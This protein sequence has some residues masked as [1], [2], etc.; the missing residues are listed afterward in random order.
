[1]AR[2]IDREV[3]D[4]H[5]RIMTLNWQGLPVM[6]RTVDPV[7]PAFMQAIIDLG[8]LPPASGREARMHAIDLV[9]QYNAR[10]TG[11]FALE[12]DGRVSYTLTLPREGYKRAH[13]ERAIE[14]RLIALSSMIRTM[15]ESLKRL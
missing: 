12:T 5:G 14:V 15:A 6:I 4:A 9:L 13:I 10:V 8:C 7:N 3:P 11:Q 2:S 1:M